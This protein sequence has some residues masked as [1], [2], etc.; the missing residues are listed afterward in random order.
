MESLNPANPQSGAQQG[1][2]TFRLCIIVLIELQK[3]CFLTCKRHAL[4]ILK[5]INVHHSHVAQTGQPC[6]VE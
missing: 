5:T 1:V 4:C 6:N 2:I 3:C